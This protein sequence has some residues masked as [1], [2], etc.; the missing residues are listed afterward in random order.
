MGLAWCWNDGWLQNEG[1]IDYSGASFVHTMGG[2]AGFIGTYIIG[3]RE[4]LFKRDKK[5][6]YILEE[7][8]LLDDSDS[9]DDDLDEV[10]IPPTKKE[11]HSIKESDDTIDQ[12]EKS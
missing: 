3:P 5:L 2:L 1:F 6:E 4:G 7:T 10:Y 9:A 11:S 12:M 8:K